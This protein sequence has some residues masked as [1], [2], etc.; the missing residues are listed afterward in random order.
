MDID[1]AGDVKALERGVYEFVH[2][3]EV[4]EH[5]PDPRAA[6]RRV[7]DLLRPRGV[8]CVVVPN[9]YNVLQAAIRSYAGEQPWWLAPPHHINYFTVK[10]IYNLLSAVGFRIVDLFTTF[11]MEF[12]LLA[13]AHYID[14]PAVGRHCHAL[15][16]VFEINMELAGL[17]TAK[18]QLYRALANHGVGRDI[19]IFGRKAS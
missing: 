8:V 4:L 17:G 18:R 6:L 19:V 7:V 12:F 11:P 9:D 1:P 5:V 10:S 16:K 3:S 2:M 13:G 14:D 15:R